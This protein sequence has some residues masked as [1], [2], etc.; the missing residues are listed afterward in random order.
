MLEIVGIIKKIELVCF[1]IT[2][3]TKRI[4]SVERGADVMCQYFASAGYCQLG[5][6]QF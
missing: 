3:V 1:F 4:A 5:T 6:S 2:P